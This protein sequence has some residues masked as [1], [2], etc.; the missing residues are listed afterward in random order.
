M[1]EP[2]CEYDFGAQLFSK[3]TVSNFRFD[4]QQSS[5]GPFLSNTLRKEL[6]INGAFCKSSDRAIFVS[7]ERDGS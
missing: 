7:K 2:C 6:Q 5:L 4:V 1:C 3:E